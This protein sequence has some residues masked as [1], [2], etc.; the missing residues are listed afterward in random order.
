MSEPKTGRVRA[1]RLDP[2]TRRDLIIDA[3]ETLLGEHDPLLV[4][5][6][7]VAEAAGVSRPLVHTYLGDHRGLVDA[8]QV[9][10]I[11]RLDRWVNHGLKRVASPFE[12]WRA[13]VYGVFSFVENEQDAW[14]VLVSTGGLDHPSLHGLRKRWTQA[15]G[16]TE[17]QQMELASQAAIA[18][19]LLGAGGWVTRGVDPDEF[20]AVMNPTVSFTV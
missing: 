8:V 5:F 6:S 12:T 20:I 13:L 2:V 10:M 3:A 14:S 17:D 7:H 1:A 15:I 19:L 16:L 18:A 11:T 4:T 9:R